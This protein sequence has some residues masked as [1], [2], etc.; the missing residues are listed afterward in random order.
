M[1]FVSFS[2]K[3]PVFCP[4]FHENP[5][6]FEIVVDVFTTSHTFLDPAIALTEN[7]TGKTLVSINIR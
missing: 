4:A 3:I 2:I 1:Y 5:G 7:K 6:G